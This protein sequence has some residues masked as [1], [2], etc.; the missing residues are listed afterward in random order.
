MPHL[1]SPARF[2]MYCFYQ[3]LV[4]SW[5]PR[6]LEAGTSD[7]FVQFLGGV[8]CL[9]RFCS[10]R[11]DPCTLNSLAHQHIAS[12][13]GP[14]ATLSRQRRRVHPPTPEPQSYRP[15]RRQQPSRTHQSASPEL[16]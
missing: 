16:H 14:A 5:L 10:R 2:S 1:R 12:C 11:P 7:D 15:D 6:G 9:C 8:D 3:L 4:R 13:A